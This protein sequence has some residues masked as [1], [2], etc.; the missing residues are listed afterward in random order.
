VFTVPPGTWTFTATTPKP[1]TAAAD[2]VAIEP[3]FGTDVPVI[4]GR[5]A[6]HPFRVTNLEDHTMTV[7]PHVTTSA[8]F[9]AAVSGGAVRVPAHGSATI[10][11]TV[12]RTGAATGGT[13]TLTAPGT[14]DG[15]GASAPVKATAN[16]VRDAAMTASSTH[17]GSDAAWANDGGTD[18]S[19]WLNGV[20]GWNDD[21][22][23]Q[24]PDTL[25]ATWAEPVKIGRVKLF[26]LDSAKYPAAK[27]GLRDF[28]VQVRDDGGTAH[29]RSGRGGGWR[30]VSTVTGNTSGTVE[31]TFPAATTGA[32]RV[33]VHDTN[34]HA[35]SR[36]IELEGYGS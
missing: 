9:A 25:T 7:R 2:Q 32:L 31:R 24:F 34:D 26:T 35:S 16:L 1:V 30:T 10:P 29:G 14:D 12:T 8:G 6:A 33:V 36:V 4:D 27:V 11:V 19:V 17:S 28:D 18:S 5:P 13:V 15:G 20:G 22:S 3:P 23:K 21:T